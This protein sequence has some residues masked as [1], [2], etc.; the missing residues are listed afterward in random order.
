MK[1]S[2]GIGLR[3]EHYSRLLN[4]GVPAEI[5]FL[6]IISENYMASEGR[7]ME[8]VEALRQERPIALHGVS[9][10]IGSTDRLGKEYLR[11]LGALRKRLQAHS[12]S[13]H[14]CW[15]GL[16]GHN[17]H[18]LLPLP[19]TE[20]TLK[21][22]VDRVRETQ[23]TLQT[24]IALEN[25]S[26]YVKFASSTIKETDFLSELVRETSCRLLLDLNNVYV[27]SVNFGFD[28]L[29]YLR[30]F[31]IK[32][33]EQ[34]HLAGHSKMAGY[35]FDTHSTAVCNEV[36]ALYRSYLELGGRAPVLIEWDDQVPDLERLVQEVQQAK[37]IWDECVSRHAQ[38]SF[39]GH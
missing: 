6:E 2:G 19:Y 8:T 22:V 23:D 37:V 27:N 28:P 10:S 39:S 32:S 12:V 13:D 9:L 21:N 4:G 1:F 38:V 11:K 24:T 26:A 7:P 29:E 16:G 35:L 30:A 36:W 5:S 15:T 31:P 33:V 3:K 25:P 18:D 20:K 34:I 17:T 14:L